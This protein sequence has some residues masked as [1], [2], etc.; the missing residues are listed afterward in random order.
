MY[1]RLLYHLGKRCLPR[2]ERVNVIREAHTSLISGHFGVVKTVAQL[3]RYCYWPRMNE[4]I[5]KY[6]KGCVMCATSK[7]SNKNLGLYTPV[8]IPSQPWESISMDFVG[9]LPMSKIGHDDLNV[10]VD[11]FNKMCIL[12]LC[13]KHVTTE[14]TTHMLFANVWVH[15]GL[16]TSIISD[17]DSRFLGKFWSHLWELM[18]T[19]LKKSTTFHPW[20]NGQTKVVN[21]IVVHLL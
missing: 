18:D 4:T 21:I 15:F 16:P 6:I 19:K 2:D 11:R 20:K 5:S 3:Q 1:D 14:H 12:I 8:P 13:K 10:M 17:R 7:P 9:G